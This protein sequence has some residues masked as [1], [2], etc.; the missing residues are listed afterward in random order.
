MYKAQLTHVY[1]GNFVRSWLF[2]KS[3]ND[4]Y[5]LLSYFVHRGYIENKS[6]MYEERFELYCINPKDKKSVTLFSIMEES[7]RLY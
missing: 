2:H 6:R 7:K 1:S 3:F 5:E 4:K